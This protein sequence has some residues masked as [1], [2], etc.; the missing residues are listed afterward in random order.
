MAHTWTPQVIQLSCKHTPLVSQHAHPHTVDTC[1]RQTQQV[2]M[3]SCS[4]WVPCVSITRETHAHPYLPQ[5]GRPNTP[6]TRQQIQWHATD[7]T[8]QQLQKQD[9]PNKP[10]TSQGRQGVV[11]VG[12]LH[13]HWQLL[14]IQHQRKQVHNQ[15]TAPDG[16]TDRCTSCWDRSAL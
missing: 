7:V 2:C 8:Q 10:L 9:A 16:G 5:P 3:S 12:L 4:T 1:A 13:T 15:P 14:Q 6:G 11:L